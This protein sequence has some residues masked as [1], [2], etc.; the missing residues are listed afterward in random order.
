MKNK[1]IKIS[2]I[3]S[4]TS[5]F[6]CSNM[7]EADRKVDENIEN[8]NTK[9]LESQTKVK[10]GLLTRDNDI[11]VAAKSHILKEDL[12]ALPKYFEEHYTFRTNQE[13]SIVD[14]VSKISTDTKTHIV[15]SGDARTY[16]GL[17]EDDTNHSSSAD[18]DIVDASIS[19]KGT[20]AGL[21][22]HISSIYNIDWKYDF[23]TRTIVLYRMETKVFDLHMLPG[24][25]TTNSTINSSQNQANNQQ[26]FKT[27]FDYGK[28][29]SWVTAVKTIKGIV[30]SEGDTIASPEMGTLTVTATPHVMQKVDRYVERV[31][32]IAKK[33]IAV[34]VDV[35]DVINRNSNTL[36]LDW[37][38]LYTST[39]GSVNWVT[40]FPNI[41]ADPFGTAVADVPSFKLGAG[42]GRWFNSEVIAKALQRLGKTSHVT[43]TTL[44]TV[45]GKPAPIQDT[46]A[47]EYAKEVSLEMSGLGNT[48]ASVTPGTINTGYSI[49]VTPKVVQGDKIMVNISLNMSELIE[50]RSFE[51]NIDD[52]QGDNPKTGQGMKIELPD[53]QNKTFM[54]MVPLQSGQTA[55]LAGFQKTSEVSETN[56]AGP[57]W[58]WW[59]LGGNTGTSQETTTTVVMVTPYI[60]E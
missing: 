21:L 54:Q 36:G 23:K 28:Y 31:N 47:V 11:L 49:V 42:A 7:I 4:L 12:R 34:K 2:L 46:R 15:I 53:V 37:K 35:Y 13:M 19:Y 55:V 6:A 16:L 22:D 44:Y 33:R 38:L 24:V 9:M 56:S 20:F 48:L 58:S 26:A 41:A 43:G 29:D 60:M 39:D 57:L 10:S 8:A 32:K 27:N 18:E 1:I 50:M 45:S 52:T 40:K 59:L 25:T 17:V 14:I 3:L 51:T 30:G 5:L